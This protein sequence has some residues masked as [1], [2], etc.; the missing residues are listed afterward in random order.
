MLKEVR[1]TIPA[2][3]T[4]V[5]GILVVSNGAGGDTRDGYKE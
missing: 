1:L 3:L 5:R 4:M 2:G